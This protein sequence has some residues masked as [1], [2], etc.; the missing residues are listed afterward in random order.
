[1]T[2]D[3]L[4]RYEPVIGLEVHAQ[5]L[6]ATKLFCGCKTEFGALPN[7][8]TCPVC[9]GHPGTLPVVN[10]HAVDMALKMILAVGGDVKRHSRFSRKNYFYPDLPKGY[11]I[12]QY[13]Q[14]LSIGGA[15]TVTLPDHEKNIRL[16]RIHLE[17]DAGKS[18][19]PE[20]GEDHT[21]IDFNRCGIPLIEIVTEP[22]IGSPQEAHAFLVK[23][24]QIMQYL[25]ICSGDM[26]KGALRCDA[27]V[28]LRPKGDREHGIR[29]ELKNLNS[30]RA[31]ERALTYEIERQ[32]HLLDK[33]M[34]IEQETLLWNEAT[35][36]TEPMRG[37]EM[38]EDYRYFPEPDL[39]PLVIEEKRITGIRNDIPELPD[40]RR[41]R[42]EKEYGIPAYDA[43]VLAGTKAVADYFE[44]A[45]SGI[46]DRKSLSNWVMVEV[47]HVVNESNIDIAEFAVTPDML[48]ELIHY[49]ETKTVTGKMAKEIFQEM[50]DTG[51]SAGVI[52]REKELRRISD[53]DQLAGIINEILAEESEQ[54]EKYKQGK[55]KLFEFFVGQV[56]K[57]TG[58]K[59]DPRMTRQILEEK[60]DG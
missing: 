26:E 11:Q 57:R 25:E 35:R 22:D 5:L 43:A 6:T 51:R 42:M 9:L 36:Q 27:N 55:T 15:V 53:R 37:K 4:T 32:A 33:G 45:A 41:A 3:V 8:R 14:P 58:G 18:L 13:D 10:G 7:L 12:S 21:R 29:T 31:V 59:A 47:L 49:L 24:K 23:L 28:S 44:E 46:S 2:D 30:F 34:R 17:E 56:M 54:A 50:V 48:S 20:T 60:L 52:I 40:H 38:S 19:H 39:P 16:I 1:M